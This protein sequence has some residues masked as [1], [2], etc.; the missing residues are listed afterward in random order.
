MSQANSQVKRK[1]FAKTH[2]NK[3]L[4]FIIGALIKNKCFNLMMLLRQTNF[5]SAMALNFQPCF[6]FD[7]W[8]YGNKIILKR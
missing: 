5:R 8:I 1:T 7:V 6:N 2:E 3:G 4:A